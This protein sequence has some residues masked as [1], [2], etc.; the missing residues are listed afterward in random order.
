MEAQKEKICTGG[1]TLAEMNPYRC[2]QA[3]YIVEILSSMSNM[4]ATEDRTL[5]SCLFPT[6]LQIDFDR[7]NTSLA[8]HLYDY[9]LVNVTLR[10]FTFTMFF[11]RLCF[12]DEIK[13][14]KTIRLSKHHSDVSDLSL[15]VVCGRKRGRRDE[16]DVFSSMFPGRIVS[17]LNK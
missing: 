8:K 12:T 5:G 10:Q 15:R 9:R 1:D 3:V 2:T 13:R 6:I 16:V 11:F 7:W 4:N 17:S 14:T